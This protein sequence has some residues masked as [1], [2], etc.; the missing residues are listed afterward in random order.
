MNETRRVAKIRGF[1]NSFSLRRGYKA[2]KYE[3]VNNFNNTSLK[4]CKKFDKEN[5]LVYNK[6]C[7]LYNSIVA[8]LEKN[9]ALFEIKT[10]P[11]GPRTPTN[12]EYF[13]IHQMRNKEINNKLQTMAVTYLT[14]NYY[15]LVIDSPRDKIDFIKRVDNKYYEPY[16][17]VDLARKV[18]G[19]KGENFINV[20]KGRYRINCERDN[21]SIN[22]SNR[23]SGEL[24]QVSTPLSETNRY[25]DNRRQVTNLNNL[26][27]PNSISRVPSAPQP[28]APPPLPMPSSPNNIYPTQ[29]EDSNM[30]HKH[31]TASFGNDFNLETESVISA[32]PSYNG[33]MAELSH[34]RS[35]PKPQRKK[36]GVSI[37]INQ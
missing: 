31:I 17:A 28:S 13:L 25:R 19:E 15:D 21:G 26:C 6:N 14:M 4:M 16:M 24:E 3:Y 22:M 32:P 27:Y 10:P 12:E 2:V 18:A 29:M 37:V 7:T 8:K 20:V 1:S 36:K 9:N 23:L 33:M 30:S 34:S 35:P 11:Q 5:A